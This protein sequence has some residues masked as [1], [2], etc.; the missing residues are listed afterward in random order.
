MHMIIPAYVYDNV[1][2]KQNVGKIACSKIV[3]ITTIFAR[4]ALERLA[5]SVVSRL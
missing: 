5:T 2:T 1:L 3:M 4:Q